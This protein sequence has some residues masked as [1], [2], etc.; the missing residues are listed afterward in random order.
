MVL[1]ANAL[2]NQ[3]SS[4]ACTAIFSLKSDE[5]WLHKRGGRY[6]N[7]FSCGTALAG[8]QSAA[9]SAAAAGA[10]VASAAGLLSSARKCVR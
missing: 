3:S 1:K 6:A 7:I 5:K 10:A 2:Q 4:S 9:P 8:A